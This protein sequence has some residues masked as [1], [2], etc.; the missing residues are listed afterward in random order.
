MNEFNI[1]AAISCCKL[2]ENFFIK[3]ADQLLN[4]EKKKLSDQVVQNALYWAQEAGQSK[5]DLHKIIAQTHKDVILKSSYEPS[6]DNNK[7]PN[8]T[9]N[10]TPI[11]TSTTNEDPSVSTSS[12]AIS[13]A[14]IIA[15][16]IIII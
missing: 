1:L 12:E 3:Y 16:Y 11:T 4:V 10:K 5:E 14:S 13:R 2:D 9:L 6:N 7:T 15:Y 8:K